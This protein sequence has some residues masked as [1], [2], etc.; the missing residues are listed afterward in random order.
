M[1]RIT[2]EWLGSRVDSVNV[3]LGRPTARFNSNDDMNV[4]HLTL[5]KNDAGYKLVEIIS[6]TGGEQVWSARLSAKHMDQYIDGIINGISLRNAHIGAMLLKNELL[7]HVNTPVT[8][9]YDPAN[10]STLRKLREKV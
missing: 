6:S 10:E 7:H 4:G 3:V 8:A 1:A 2:K 9:L 5:D